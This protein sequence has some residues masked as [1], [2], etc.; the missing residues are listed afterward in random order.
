MMGRL[1]EAHT[2]RPWARSGWLQRQC[3]MRLTG[4]PGSGG[5]QRCTA[6]PEAYRRPA[7]S[8]P[9]TLAQRDLRMSVQTSPRS[10]A[11]E[12]RDDILSRSHRSLAAFIAFVGMDAVA[13][14]STRVSQPPLLSDEPSRE[15]AG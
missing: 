13:G 1:W 12:Q 15:S 9:L 3:W 10:E 5:S 8:S 2:R 7:D 6:F 14:V 4:W 11:N